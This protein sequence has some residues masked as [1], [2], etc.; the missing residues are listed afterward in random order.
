MK[1]DD[2]EPTGTRRRWQQTAGGGTGTPEEAA[3]A[4]EASYSREPETPY[5]EQNRAIPSLAGSILGAFAAGAADRP[6]GVFWG[7][8]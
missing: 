6:L 8:L 2:A 4:H 3:R 5:T 1:E 7:A